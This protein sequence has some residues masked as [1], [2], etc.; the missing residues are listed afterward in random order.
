MN[1]W[2]QEHDIWYET[3]YTNKQTLTSV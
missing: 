2:N 3:H 1:H